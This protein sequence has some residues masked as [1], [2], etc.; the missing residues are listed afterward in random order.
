M[1][2]R[3]LGSLTGGTGDVNPQWYKLAV[4]QSAADTTTTTA[5]PLPVPKVQS[6]TRPVVIEVL[7]TFWT[8]NNAI[9]TDSWI[10]GFLSTKSYGTTAPS[11]TDGGIVDMFYRDVHITT[12]GQITYFMPQI[13]ELNDSAGHGVLVATDNV[14]LQAASSATSLANTVTCW[15]L[16]RMKEVSLAEYIGIV[17]S[18]Q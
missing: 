13:H 12:S 7:R 8:N 1:S 17:Q 14:Y 15:I 10:E 5:F 9:E 18:Q 6:N 16:Y 11:F 2:K 3:G 4:T